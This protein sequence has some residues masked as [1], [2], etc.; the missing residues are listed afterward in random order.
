MERRPIT[1]AITYVPERRDPLASA[2]VTVWRLIGIVVGGLILFAVGLLV[3]GFAVMIGQ[4]LL[5]LVGIDTY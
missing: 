5:D 1:G 4:W 2:F 3:A